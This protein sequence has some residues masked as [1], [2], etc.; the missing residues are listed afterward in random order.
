MLLIDAAM[1]SVSVLFGVA[2]AAKR[3]GPPGPAAVLNTVAIL[4]C[5]WLSVF[6]LSGMYR[7]GLASSAKDEVYFGAAG[8]LIGLFP[9]L[10]LSA[11]D[12]ELAP[13]KLLLLCALIAA[14]LVGL[15]KALAR[16]LW[17]DVYLRASSSAPSWAAGGHANQ[18]RGA[19]GPA[20]KLGL[21][22]VGSTL[23]SVVLAPVIAIA[24]LAVWW[25]S[26]RP[27]LF[28]QERV[29]QGGRAFRIFKFRSMH[30]SAGDQWVK[31]GDSRITKVGALLRRTSVDE[32]PQLLNIMRGEMS[33]VGPRPEMTAFAAQFSQTL[34]CYDER[35]VVRPGMTGWAQVS[36]KRV[37]DPADAPQVLEHDLFYVRHHSL[38][39]DVAILLK[40]AVEFLFHRVV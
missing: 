9:L 31:P 13:V 17:P 35:H 36:M 11:A 19:L 4:T 26:G 12:T 2:L 16:T 14:P 37:L 27:V 20:A 21:D 32:L 1:L 40:T 7:R 28:R 29:G 5:G 3:A 23:A 15:A 10:L 39:M 22:A 38:L 34:P 18:T 25:E 30:L 8:V 24:A 6:L 33:L